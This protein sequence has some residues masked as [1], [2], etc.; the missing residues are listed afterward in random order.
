MTKRELF[1]FFIQFPRWPIKAYDRLMGLRENRQEKATPLLYVY[2][3]QPVEAMLDAVGKVLDQNLQPFFH[4]AELAEIE[5]EV[6]RGID[7]IP[8]QGA[9]TRK[10]NSSF[11]LGRICYTLCRALKPDRVLETGVAFGVCSSFILQALAVNGIW[12]WHS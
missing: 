2:Q 4:E 8:K 5:A 7:D 12:Q 3:E 11:V 10:H 6:K 9:F 1:E